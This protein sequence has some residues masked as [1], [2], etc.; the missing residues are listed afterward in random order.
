[1]VFIELSA[2]IRILAVAHAKREPGYW[3]NRIQP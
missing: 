1:L 2:E 3:L